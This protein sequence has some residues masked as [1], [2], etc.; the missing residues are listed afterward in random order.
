MSVVITIL[1]ALVIIGVMITA[2]EFGHF[3][4]GRK[5]GFR[6]EEF[7]IGMG[8]KLFKKQ[9]KGYVFSLRALPIGGYVKFYG[10]DERAADSESFNSKKC[11]K[12]FCVLS[13]GALFNILAA[14]L[15]AVILV[16]AYGNYVPQITAV[17]EDTPAASA[18]LQAGD[19]IVGVNGKN[20]VFYNDVTTYIDE[21]KTP[22][23]TFQVRRGEETLK[24]T[25]E[26]FFN[27]EK[28]QTMV[29]IEIM[30][31]RMKYGI[32]ETVS[33]AFQT[34][35]YAMREMLSFIGKLVTFQVGTEGIMG[36]VGIVDTV[37]QAV[38]SGFESVLWL[39]MI[40]GLNL[41]IV[42][43]LPFP[44]LDGGRLVFVGIEAIRR[45]PIAAEK[46]AIVH[47][48]GLLLL[49]GVMILFTYQDIV[50]LISG[51]S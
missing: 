23:I 40:I 15:L 13:A 39:A 10:E 18:G 20:V 26:S 49:F 42:N 32:F 9:C 21:S 47:F 36:P 7:A 17:K 8:P 28:Q 30:A 46:E 3:I 6:I 2:H 12:R 48:V 19:I 41:G 11:W 24:I 37:G 14:F 31:A 4:V 50:R 27:E 45:K 5:L 35:G 16:G 44:A 1:V 34:L 29:G 22:Q 43:L 51:G 25:S 38:K 33:I